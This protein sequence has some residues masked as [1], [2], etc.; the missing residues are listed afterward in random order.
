MN[1]YLSEYNKP[2]AGKTIYDPTTCID[3]DNDGVIDPTPAGGADGVDGGCGTKYEISTNK[4]GTDKLH[5]AG[6]TLT[7]NMDNG[8]RIGGSYAYMDM[9]IE[10]E[11]AFTKQTDR[12]KNRYKFSLS[13]PNVISNFGFSIAAR[14][15][16]EYFYTGSINFGSGTIGGDTIVD[17]QITYL[18]SDYS[19]SV[20]FGINNLLGESYRQNVGGPYIGQT[21]YVTFTY[22]N[23]LN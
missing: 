9:A 14:Y 3:A 13:N 5:G 19:T 1:Y 6:I 18:L 2:F 21:M 4:E 10:P 15:T 23:L 17:A 12:P 7:Y 8:Y 20:K 11:E 22:D 16:D